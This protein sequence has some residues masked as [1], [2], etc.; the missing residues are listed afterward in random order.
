MNLV[1]LS[2][3][4]SKLIAPACA[5]IIRLQTANPKSCPRGL[6]MKIGEKSG[7]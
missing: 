2:T 1:S 5:S 3:W 7:F 6:V 4:L